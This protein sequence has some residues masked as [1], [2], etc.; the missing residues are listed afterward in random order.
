MTLDT[1]ILH[2]T[3]IDGTGAPRRPAAVGI[4]GRRVVSVGAAAG[5][6]KRVI[7]AEGLVVAPGF[8]DI[9]THSCA[10]LLA[11][12]RGLSAL[13]QGVTTHVV[14]NCGMS[15]WP[16]ADMI[17]PFLERYGVERD[18]TDLAG[19][20]SRL[21]RRGTG[22][23]LAPLVGHGTVRAMVVGEDDREPTPA[24]LEWMKG[25]V[26]H[27]MEQGA[28]GLSTGL[29]YAPGCFATPT[30]IAALAGVAARYGGYYATHLRNEGG[31][32]ADAV[33]E[34]IAI[35]ERAKVPVEISHLKAADRRWWGRVGEVLAALDRARAKGIDV[36]WDQYPYTATSTGLD[37]FIPAWAH[38]GGAQE[39]KKRLRA[40]DT[41]RRIL[42]E[43]RRSGKNWSEVLIIGCP[44]HPEWQQLTPPEIGARLGLGPEE[45]ILEVVASET[46]EVK[47]A[48]FAMCEEDVE[49]ILRHPVTL[50]GS[51]GV[52]A[53]AEGPIGHLRFHPRSYGTF[54]RV[55]GRYVRERGVL[56]LEEAL[57]KMTSAPARRLGLS[58]R[59]VLREGMRADITVFDP[60]RVADRA[61]FEDPQRYPE[62]IVYVLVNGE[63][64]LEEGRFTGRLAGEL[65][66]RGAG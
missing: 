55:L 40:D 60:A 9:H 18:W 8:I 59:G 14:G 39:M 22:V 66:V 58:D 31:G 61:T 42:A 7:D 45:A 21:R 48:N 37:F 23:N 25:L 47:M 5:P 52:A 29:T 54:P 65:L 20:A 15:I 63:P 16:A 57:R 46:G 32:L 1:V 24:E 35:G 19:Y 49:S 17:R 62:G 30:E 28:F 4:R 41:R 3:L 6:A 56:S 13:H 27:A 64:V 34:A 11:D 53:A 12:P 10:A 38:A 36:A 2:G 33:Q 43:M 44:E 51:D 50:V 26:A